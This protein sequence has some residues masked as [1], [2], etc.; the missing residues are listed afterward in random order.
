[1]VDRIQRKLKQIW[2]GRSKSSIITPDGNPKVLAC[3]LI[4]Q[5]LTNG[6]R[7]GGRGRGRGNG[8]RTTH[9]D[10]RG[11]GSATGKRNYD[12]TVPY[13]PGECK[14]CFGKYNILT[15]GKPNMVNDCQ[16]K[17]K[18]RASRFFRE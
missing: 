5:N 14:Y 1:M 9:T 11:R 16:K 13:V 6:D 18:D 17:K 7:G 15:G 4:G 3:N 12:T 2:G 10:G 8:G